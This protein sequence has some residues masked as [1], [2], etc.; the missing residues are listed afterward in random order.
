M[1]TEYINGL[2]IE[3]YDGDITELPVTRFQVFSKY[4]LM[5]SKIGGTLSDIDE[6]IGR[7]MHYIE[8]DPKKALI[9]VQNMRLNM[10]FILEGINPKQKAFAALI[11]KINGVPQ[12]DLTDEGIKRVWE[13]LNTQ[14]SK[15]WFDR[16]C[17]AVKK[18]WMTG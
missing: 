5:D 16:I 15:T 12:N 7:L 2:K 10:Y 9:E 4:V 1:R 17:Q 8:K 18:K 3:F 13:K 14:V 11:Y 6:H